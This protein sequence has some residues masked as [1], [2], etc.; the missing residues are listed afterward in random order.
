MLEKLKHAVDDATKRGKWQSRLDD[1]RKQY[2]RKIMDTREALYRGDKNIRG[3]NGTDAEKKATNVRN[4]V[5][6]LIES[7]VDSSIP[8]PRVTAI[9]EEDK[10]L[11]KKIEALLLNLSKQLNLKELNDLQERTVPIQGGDFFHVEWDPHGGYHCMLGDVTVTE[12]HP[13]QVIPQPG[14]Y[15]I[16]KMEYIFILVSQPKQ[17]LERRYGVEIKDETEDDLE[18]RGQN[19][20]SVS[21]IVTQNIAY[22]RNNDGGIGMYSW[23]GDVTLE[24]LDNCQKRR[25]KVCEKCGRPKSGDVCECGSKKFVEGPLDVQE[26]T[27]DITIFGGETVAASTP[28]KDELVMNPDGTPQVDEEGV[29]ITMPGPNVPTKIPYYEPKEIPVVLRSNVRM[30]GRFLGVSDVDVIEDQQ[31]AIKKFGTKIEEKLLKGG[32]YVTLPQGVQVET[33]D[34]ELKIMRLK[35][36]AEKALISVINVQPDTSREQQML[37]SNYNWAKSTLGINDSFQGKYDASA[38]SGSAKQ[39]AAQQAAGRLQSKREMKN[40][41]Y[42]R[43][44]KLLFKYMLAYADQPYPMTYTAVGGEQTFA[45][46]N[47]WDF[48]KRDAAGEL[49]WDDEFIF[50]VDPSPNMDANRE[51]LWD[52]ADVKY[53]AGAFGPIGDLITSYRFWT[54]L[55]DNGFPGA[56]KVKTEIKQQM[57]EQ[58]QMQQAAM[59]PAVQQAMQP[60]MLMTDSDHL[61]GADV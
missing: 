41:A 55:E 56:G 3:A 53:Q 44:Y 57:D 19:Q 54:Y 12:R 38:T 29:A 28:G 13:K 52:M 10:E 8:A 18:S 14:V 43:L 34:K 25:G 60:D 39:F 32:S 26:L 21:G 58:Q 61:E 11:A 24:D 2:D 22:Y 9:H 59:Q 7:Q 40:Q 30:F 23:C 50:G 37:E 49:Y 35:N 17:Y 46:F 15:D 36:P 5:Y 42:A 31:N 6:E 27:E 33:S 48:L 1:A 4:I 45:H 51:R 47:R 16:E 20:S